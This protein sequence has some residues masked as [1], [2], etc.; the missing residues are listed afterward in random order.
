MADEIQS[1]DFSIKTNGA[2]SAKATLVNLVKSVGIALNGTTAEVDKLSAKFDK[3][4]AAVEKQ[5]LKVDELQQKLT[6]L[7]SG[8]VAPKS[9]SLNNLN[10]EFEKTIATIEKLEQ[11]EDELKAKQAELLSVFPKDSGMAQQLP[12][13]KALESELA[14]VK[15]E[16]EQARSKSDE[17][18]NSLQNAQ[19]TATQAEIQKTTTQLDYEKAKLTELEQTADTAGK[20]MGN[21]M[22][23]F[24]QALENAGTT[25]T[26]FGAR[27]MGLVKRVFVFTLI[28]KGLRAIRDTIGAVLMS[29]SA[30]VSSLNQLQ[31]ALWTAFAPILEVAVPAL[32]VLVS[33]LTAAVRAVTTFIA[34]I[35]GK[36]TAQ[37]EKEGAAIKKRVEAYKAS[38]NA[39]EKAGKKSAKATEKETK[40]LNKQLASFDELQTL[41]TNKDEDTTDAGG[42]DVGGAGGGGAGGGDIGGGFNITPISQKLVELA[43]VIGGVLA[44]VGIILLFTGN[45]AIGIGFIIAGATL[46]SVAAGSDKDSDPTLTPRQKLAEFGEY[47]GGAL[48]VIGIILIFLGH[49]PLGVAAVVA[50]IGIFGVSEATLQEGGITSKVETFLKENEDIITGLALITLVLGVIL[51][52]SGILNPLSIG[53]VAA[54]AAGLAAE[55][56]IQPG[57][58]SEKIKNFMTENANVISTIAVAVLV[59]GIIMLVCGIITPLSIGLVVMGAGLLATEIALNWDKVKNSVTNFMNDNAKAI[60]LVSVFLLVIGIILCATGAALPLGIGLI[61]VGA[62]GL[63]SEIALNWDTIKTK[64][65]NVFNSI[66]NWVKTWGLL[67]LGILLCFTGVGIPLGIGLISKAS[68][69]LADAK[70]PLWDTILDTLKE[71]WQA[72]KDWFNTHVKKYLTAKWWGDLAKNAVKGLVERFIKGLNKLITKINS[73]GF[74]LPDI[75]GGG[76]IGFNIKKLDL[77][78]LAQGTVVPPNKEFAAILGDN[79]KEPEIVSPISTMEQ[80]VENVLSR[81]GYSNNSAP[82]EVV[83]K[84]NDR[85]F[86]R[87]VVEL[88]GR[89]KRVKGNTFVKT[90]LIYG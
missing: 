14:T 42:A 17:L 40:A 26:K 57:T 80:A 79:K 18:A 31:S 63:A 85:E 83:L 24:K 69:N 67:V 35:T 81:M 5:K 90:K 22:N 48:A 68:Q 13:Y 37:M 54:G 8:E 74:D 65:S 1:I 89:A 70:D 6:K 33:W 7:S 73:F 71:K 30:F 46:Y 45:I 28:T 78:A 47:V 3:A 72:I 56:A 2:K 39:A 12:E 60:T 82:T 64:V 20:K 84:V 49:I 50:G 32:K 25:V 11:K 27:I 23:P 21:A 29:D 61:A 55:I 76:H 77:P 88:G 4:T 10:K 16:L 58:I 62:V 43:K 19:G 52:L 53:L 34:A 51:L 15:T 41:Q 75:L 59:L 44:A 38:G 86:G 66:V 87:A 36:S 9:T